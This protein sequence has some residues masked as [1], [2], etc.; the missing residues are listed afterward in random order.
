MSTRRFRVQKCNAITL[1]SGSPTQSPLLAALWPVSATLQPMRSCYQ[2]TR[3]RT[4]DMKPGPLLSFDFISLGLGES[5]L[6]F[7]VNK[8]LPNSLW[9]CVG[10]SP[11]PTPLLDL[12]GFGALILLNLFPDISRLDSSFLC[13]HFGS[14]RA[15]LK[16]FPPAS[17]ALPQR[18]TL[19]LLFSLPP[20]IPA[21]SW[22]IS[23]ETEKPSFQSSLG[24]RRMLIPL[25]RQS[26]Y[27]R[28][29]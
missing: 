13:H 7:K 1:G 8:F 6:S 10:F 29:K 4:N 5:R 17:T 20:V 24:D 22:L 21:N 14:Y 12:L 16:I 28:L 25:V 15:C 27:P 2:E 3:V 19:P 23:R 18:G 9:P 26:S 11:Y